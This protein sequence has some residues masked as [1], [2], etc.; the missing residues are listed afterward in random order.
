[1]STLVRREIKRIRAIA[2]DH[3]ERVREYPYA[4]L[5]PYSTAGNRYSWQHGYEGKPMPTHRQGQPASHM[6]GV[7]ILGRL[8]AKHIRRNYEIHNR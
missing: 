7:W 3:V 1:M 6:W 8:T 4:D 5:N 2:A